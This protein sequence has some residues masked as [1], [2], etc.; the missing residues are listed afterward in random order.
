MITVEG[1]KEGVQVFNLSEAWGKTVVANRYNLIVSFNCN[2]ECDN[3]LK[4]HAV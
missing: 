4:V 3:L 1:R 2:W